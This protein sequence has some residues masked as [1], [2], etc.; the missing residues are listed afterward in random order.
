M[1]I[2]SKIG[3][4]FFLKVGPTVKKTMG[5]LPLKKKGVT[6]NL[7]TNNADIFS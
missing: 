5:K 4:T 1:F 6:P 3:M 7:G 2:V